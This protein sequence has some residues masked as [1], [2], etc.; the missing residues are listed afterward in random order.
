MNSKQIIELDNSNELLLEEL[1]QK[2]L[3]EI[4][5]ELSKQA[6]NLVFGKGSSK[7]EIFFIGEAPGAKEDELGIPFVGRAGKELDKMLSYLSLNLEECYIANVLKYR[8]PKNR[9]PKKDEIIAHLPYLF[10]QIE[11]IKPKILVPLGNYATKLVLSNF[12]VDEMKKIQGVSELHATLHTISLGRDNITFQVF[13][14]FHPSAMMYNP[15]LRD[16]FKED[17]KL[18]AQ[19]LGKEFKEEKQKSLI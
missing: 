19:F 16:V 13:P 10:E 7:A 6:Q 2:T 9:D 11:I 3:R 5:D 12:N 1:R 4:N 8:P 18:L 15:K 14:I 17:F